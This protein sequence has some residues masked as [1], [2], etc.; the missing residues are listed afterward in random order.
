VHLL[1]DEP[2]QSYFEGEGEGPYRFCA[3]G[4]D[5][6]AVTCAEAV[7]VCTPDTVDTDEVRC[8]EISNL[9]TP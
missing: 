2:L 3:P 7:L 4:A 9:P 5:F 8:A 1:S 6:D